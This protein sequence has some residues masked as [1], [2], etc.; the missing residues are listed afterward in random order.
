MFDPATDLRLDGRVALV[1]GGTRGIGRA[2]AEALAHAGASVA[3]LARKAPELAETAAALEAL[4]ARTITVAGSA[5]D[6]DVIEEAVSRCVGELGALDL[7][8]NNAAA[9]P[10]FGPVVDVEPRAVRKILEVNLEGPIQLIQAAWRAHLRD[11]GGAI[12]NLAST[13]GIHPAPGIGV[14]NVSKAALIH[15]TRQLAV[16]L[17]PSVRVNALAPGIVK[18]D[19]AKALWAPDEEG[20]ARRHP[21]R[22]IGRPDD[23]AGLALYL[24][25]D[26][27]SWITGEVYHLDGGLFLL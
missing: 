19:F 14:Y 24:L 2:I 17:A 21:L 4:G 11:H 5:G 13:G 25:S 27:A 6:P 9:N 12:L 3:V 10:A 18:T 1:T 7:L 20:L 26:A 16:E 15:L 8:V 23:V 22:R